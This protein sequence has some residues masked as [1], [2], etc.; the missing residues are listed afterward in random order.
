MV[1]SK[2]GGDSFVEKSALN[3]TQVLTAATSKEEAK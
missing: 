2:N 1:G 3:C